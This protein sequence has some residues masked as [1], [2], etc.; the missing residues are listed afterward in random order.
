VFLVRKKS[1]ADG[2]MDEYY[3]MVVILT[4]MRGA[5][6]APSMTHML[7]LTYVV[8]VKSFFNKD[9]AFPVTS[10]RHDNIMLIDH[11]STQFGV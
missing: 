1:N 6:T 4:D 11:Q 8:L 3:M 2:F 7:S 5:L 10:N 9:C